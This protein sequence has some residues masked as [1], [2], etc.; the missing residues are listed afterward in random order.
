MTYT[1]G[2]EKFVK[3]NGKYPIIYDFSKSSST[4]YGRDGKSNAFWHMAYGVDGYVDG[5]KVYFQAYNDYPNEF[6]NLK[7]TD[8]RIESDTSYA[9]IKGNDFKKK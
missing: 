4:G 9:V 2:T 5:S 7:I 6:K 1:Y 8:Y 3:K